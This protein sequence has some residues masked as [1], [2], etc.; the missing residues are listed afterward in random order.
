MT[1]YPLSKTGYHTNRYERGSKPIQVDAPSDA[2]WQYRT[3]NNADIEH[4]PNMSSMSAY[5]NYSGS[6]EL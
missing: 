1:A 2:A 4:P 3:R 6:Q 5:T